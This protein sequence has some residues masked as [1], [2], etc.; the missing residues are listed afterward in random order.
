MLGWGASAQADPADNPADGSAVGPA[1]LPRRPLGRTGFQSTLFGL[2]CFPL[3]SLP[4]TDAAVE[5]IVRA[6]DLGCNYLDTAPSYGQGRS[7]ERVATALAGRPDAKDV[8]VATKTHTRTGAEAR[9]DLEGSLKRLG[10]DRVDLVQVHA[11]KDAADLE[12]ALAPEGPLKAL[13]QAREEGLVRFVGVTGHYDPVVMRR[14]IESDE[15]ATILFPLNCVDRHRHSF[16]KETLPA[17]IEQGVGR[18]AMKV[19]ASGNLVK[20][21]VPAE[22]CLRYVYALDVSTVVVGCRTV[23]EVDLAARVAREGRPLGVEERA[24]L[25][26]STARHQGPAVE[27]YKRT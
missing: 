14:A 18:V 27:W 8:F 1:K 11:V 3:G 24:A 16:E 23:E 19:F 26:D 22:P 5:V 12:R 25:L 17:A 21:G 7:E 15:F 9:R 10:R 2:G 20:K 6:L 13:Q 4:D